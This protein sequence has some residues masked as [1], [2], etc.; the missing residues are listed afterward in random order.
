MN[1]IK[2]GKMIYYK[3]GRGYYHNC[4]Q[5]I[6]FEYITHISVDEKPIIEKTNQE[7]NE[8]LLHPL[9]KREEIIIKELVQLLYRNE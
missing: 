1:Y 6:G 3:K 4:E 8:F 9:E 7:L 5:N 2:C